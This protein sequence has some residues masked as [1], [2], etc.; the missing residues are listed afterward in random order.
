MASGSGPG[1]AMGRVEWALLLSLST[2]W[3][4]SF[5]FNE[6][7]LE[8]WDPLTVVAGRVVLAAVT[9]L[10]AVRVSGYALPPIGPGWLPFLVLGVLNNAIP[11]ILIV[12]GQTR[13]ESGLAAILNATTPLFAIV[14]AHLATRDE[15][16]LPR[17]VAGG[18][19]GLAGVVVLVGPDALTGGAA[20][21]A[22]AQLAILV[23]SLSYAC[24]GVFGRRLR[25]TAP[26]V[27]ATGQ[28]TA[29]TLFMLPLALLAE[30][31]W[32]RGVP[33]PGTWAA[34]FGLAIPCTAV[35]YLIYFRL[36]ARAGATNTTLV[37]V[38]IPVS[39]T[40]LGVAFLGES[41]TGRQLAGMALIGL[42]LLTTDG[43]IQPLV[44]RP[45]SRP[46]HPR[47]ARAIPPEGRI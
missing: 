18:L 35:A 3:G 42:G 11:Y 23:A 32:E 36:L 41:L 19:V 17:T 2:I 30:R 14:V 15:R 28:M 7:L 25:G 10:A 47:P 31:P 37:T 29:S 40:V 22:L 16:L 45:I 21:V 13:L 8:A 34:L 46:G 9:L 39:A 43:R 20:G 12:W 33:G 24:A 5:L 4:V 27:I 26:L 6:V 38:L 1:Q 44:G